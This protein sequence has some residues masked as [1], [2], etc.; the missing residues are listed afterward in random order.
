MKVNDPLEKTRILNWLLKEGWLNLIIRHFI[1]GFSID[2][3]L[4]DY[5]GYDELEE[6]EILKSKNIHKNSIK[7]LE[8]FWEI[9]KS[10]DF[11]LLDCNGG[12]NDNETDYGDI[13]IGK[14]VTSKYKYYFINLTENVI[15]YHNIPNLKLN[16]N[17]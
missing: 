17:K 11:Y 14:N 6:D 3:F 13:I 15:I 12:E 1:N 9:F 10:E 16:L 7:Y 4:N 5:F 2:D 8:K